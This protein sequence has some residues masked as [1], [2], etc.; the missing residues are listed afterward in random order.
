MGTISTNYGTRTA[1]PSVSNLASLASTN[2]VCVGNVNNSSSVGGLSATAVGFKVDVKIVLAASGVSATGTLTFYLVESTDAGTT[3]SDGISPSSGSNQAASLKNA[4]LL[5]V[6][7]ANANSQ[8]VNAS[9]ELPG[10]LAPKDHSIL[11][12]NGSGAALAASG[13]AVDYTP[14]NFGD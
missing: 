3:Y 4:R 14:V 13:H 8:A 5:F 1:Y 6:A 12:L 11:V 7:T 10:Q 9:F 2:A